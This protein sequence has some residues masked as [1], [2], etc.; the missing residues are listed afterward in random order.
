MAVAYVDWSSMEFMIAASLSGDPN[1]LDFYRSG[2][3]YLT[4]AKRVGRAP[5]SATKRTHGEL[6]DRFKTGLLAAQYG[7]GPE[8]LAVRLGVSTFEAHEMLVQHHELFAVYW[9]WVDDWLA[10]TL[11]SGV[12]WTPIG[13]FCRT[14]ITEFND[15]SIAN[16]PTQSTGAD[17]LR[18][19]VVW[20]TRHKLRLLAPV[21][22]ALLLESTIDRIEADVVLLQEIMRRASRVVLNSTVGGDLELRTDAKIIKYPDRYSDPRGVEVWEPVLAL[23]AEYQARAATKELQHGAA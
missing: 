16:W 8:T 19:S 18:L 10:S 11:N 1:M 6:R 15:R 7:I 17:I 14:G 22:D 2:D 9:R 20:A 5:E 12:A 21:H 23:L 13:W 4:F 3:P